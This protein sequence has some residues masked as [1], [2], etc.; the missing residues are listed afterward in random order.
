M[1]LEIILLLFPFIASLLFTNTLS[2]QSHSKPFSNITV[3]GTVFCD[4]CSSNNFSTHSYF[5]QGVKVLLDCNFRV[6]STSKEEISIRVIR[7]TDEHGVYRLDIPPVDGFECREGRQMQSFCHASLIESSSSSLCNLPNLRSSTEHLGLMCRDASACLYNLNALSF[8]PAKKDTNLC[9][10]N[11][12][13]ESSDLSVSL[14]LWPPSPSFPFPLPFISPPNP[15]P[16]PFPL[17]FISPPSPPPFPFPL[18]S[19]S[20]PSPPPFS[21]PF[22]FPPLPTFVSPPPPPPPTFSLGDPRTWFQPPSP[23]P[24]HP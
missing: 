6:N 8:R 16:F 15:P 5:L 2:I 4:T 21:F 24:N 13:S 10:T 19:I 9:G 20:P 23:P 7:S 18:P 17:P 12:A 1:N 14:F 11:E 3:I 22:P